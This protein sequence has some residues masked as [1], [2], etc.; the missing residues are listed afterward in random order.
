MTATKTREY[1]VKQKVAPKVEKPDFCLTVSC[2]VLERLGK[3]TDLNKIKAINI[4]DNAYR[5]NVYRNM[6]TGVLITDSF[7]VRASDRGELVNAHI[8][9]KY[10][11]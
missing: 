3:P 5:V 9:K 10:P 7:F 6:P 2:E 4:Y 8:N 11:E 1:E